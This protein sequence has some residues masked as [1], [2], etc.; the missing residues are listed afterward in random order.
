MKQINY[1]DSVGALVV[2][3]FVFC[4]SLFM[5]PNVSVAEEDFIWEFK[6]PI[7]LNNL[8]RRVDYIGVGVKVWKGNTIIAEKW[9]DSKEID[10]EGSLSETIIIRIYEA[11]GAL[12]DATKYMVYLKAA[13]SKEQGAEI[14]VATNILWCKATPGSV[15]EVTR[16]LNQIK[17]MMSVPDDDK[18]VI[19]KP[20]Y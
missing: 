5:F 9:V 4:A 8:M 1:K 6:I 17:T 16:Y 2:T 7:N 20:K 14:S 11:K 18:N 19:K 15:L 3:L 12:S 13:V 10:D